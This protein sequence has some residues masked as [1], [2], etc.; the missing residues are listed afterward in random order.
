MCPG[1]IER[2]ES[3]VRLFYEVT[4]FVLLDTP[5]SK[6][7]QKTGLRLVPNSTEIDA[8][9]MKCTCPTQTQ[10]SRTQRDL[11]STC[12]CWD[13]VG[14]IGT[15]VGLTGTGLGSTRLFRYLHVG[16]PNAKCSFW[17]SR[18]TR[19]PNTSGFALRKINGFV[20]LDLSLMLTENKS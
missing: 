20:K 15:G 16:I 11:Y 9:N 10:C 8:N 6:F 7:Q 17:G 13:H 18:L 19:D 14:V 1:Y 2:P 3:T 5:K 12:S 4:H